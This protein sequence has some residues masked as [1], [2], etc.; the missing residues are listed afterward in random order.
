MCIC[1]C[2]T[3]SYLCGCVSSVFFCHLS[4]TCLICQV[5]L[6]VFTSKPAANSL[7]V[8]TWN[9]QVP[10]FTVANGNSPPLLAVFLTVTLLFLHLDSMVFRNTSNRPSSTSSS[11]SAA[12]A[13]RR[14]CTVRPSCRPRPATTATA[15]SQTPTSTTTTNQRGASRG[16]S[17]KDPALCWG[18]TTWWSWSRSSL[19]R[20]SSPPAHRARPLSR[21]RAARPNSRDF[22]SSWSPRTWRKNQQ[23]LWG[24][25]RAPQRP[26][27]RPAPLVA[28]RGHN[29]PTRPSV[30]GSC[31]ASANRRGRWWAWTGPSQ[32]PSLPTRTPAGPT[33]TPARRSY[34]PTSRRRPNPDKRLMW[35]TPPRVNKECQQSSDLR[36]GRTAENREK[37]VVTPLNWR[38]HRFTPDAT[39]SL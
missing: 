18:T 12:A 14:S 19:C 6:S 9:P 39:I 33:W 32:R 20:G 34:P 13:K 28:K 10:F 30:P 37:T 22:W 27:Q 23:R 38:P 7:F 15:T 2:S 29:P 31:S 24:Q 35:K 25:P 26:P 8:L 36:D 17:P 11:S 5:K 16:T 21:P 3:A 4:N 1:P